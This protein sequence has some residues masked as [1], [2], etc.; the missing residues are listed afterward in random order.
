[1]KGITRDLRIYIMSATLVSGMYVR[2]SE[3][4]GE[5]RKAVRSQ[6]HDLLLCK[7]SVVADA[8]VQRWVSSS[9]PARTSM[10]LLQ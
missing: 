6:R 10:R 5:I 9:L 4:E 1:M 3:T 8:A 7:H 2:V